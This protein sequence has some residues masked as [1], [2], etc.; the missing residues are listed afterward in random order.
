ME[1]AREYLSGHKMR[2]AAK[3]IEL[4]AAF[5]E[6]RKPGIQEVSVS[7]RWMS[8]LFKQVPIAGH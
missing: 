7:H 3:V 6:P 2:Y 5:A 1:R 8:Q 4:A